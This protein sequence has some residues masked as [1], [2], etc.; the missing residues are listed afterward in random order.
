MATSDMTFDFEDDAEI[1]FDDDVIS[2]ADLCPPGT[3]LVDVL[4]DQKENDLYV[5]Y[6]DEEDDLSY[7]KAASLG[8]T[9]TLQ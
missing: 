8:G 5:M 3:I 4:I 6:V 7:S 1:E 9:N 2:L